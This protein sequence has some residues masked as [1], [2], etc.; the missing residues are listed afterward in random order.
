LYFSS[1]IGDGP[2]LNKTPLVRWRSHYLFALVAH[3]L[4][5]P[6]LNGNGGVAESAL[7]HFKFTTVSASKIEEERT[8]RQ[9]TAEYDAYL[10]GKDVTFVD[11]VTEQYHDARSLRKLEMVQLQL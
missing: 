11:A 6:R 8:R 5:P 4:W 1:S 3:Q 10:N 7:L 9:H 2:A